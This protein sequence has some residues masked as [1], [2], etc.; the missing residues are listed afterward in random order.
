MALVISS[1]VFWH[2]VRFLCL[3]QIVVLGCLPG[4][5][6]LGFSVGWCLFRIVLEGLGFRF[7]CGPGDV[8]FD[9]QIYERPGFVMFLHCPIS[10]SGTFGRSGCS[11][12]RG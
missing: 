8:A 7:R 4:R 10:F 12:G 1:Q 5:S 11:P 2:F 3:S 6:G 9:W